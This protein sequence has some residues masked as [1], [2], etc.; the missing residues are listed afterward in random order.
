MQRCHL[1]LV[2][3][4]PVGSACIPGS[5]EPVSMGTALPKLIRVT[6]FGLQHNSFPLCLKT[7]FE[8]S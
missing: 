2:W 4:A 3:L 1:K 6:L 7:D 8:L 5:P